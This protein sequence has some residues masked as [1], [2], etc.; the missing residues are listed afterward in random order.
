M[1]KQSKLQITLNN[2]KYTPNEPATKKKIRGSTMMFINNCV[3][4]VILTIACRFGQL[5]LP[6]GIVLLTATFLFELW[7]FR[8][9]SKACVLSNSGDLLTLMKKCYNKKFAI[10]IDVCAVLMLFAVQICYTIIISSYVHQAYD[11]F[12][13]NETCKY[14]D[15]AC[16]VKYRNVEIVIRLII[17]FLILPFEDLITSIDI[18]NYISSFA[19][20]F[21]LVTVIC[22][23][24]RSSVTLISGQ[25]AYDKLFVARQPKI[26][27]KPNVLDIFVDFTGMFAMFSLQ[28]VI[29]PLYAE[30]VGNRDTKHKI[31]SKAS[32][33]AT[34]ALYVLYMITGVLGCL[35]FYGDNQPKYQYDNILVNYSSS[36][37]LMSI[38][39][40]IYVLVIM[41]GYPVVIFQIRAS[42]ASW[43]GFHLSWCDCHCYLLHNR[44][45][46]ALYSHDF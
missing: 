13:K 46:Y 15:T 34:F 39:R 6:L 1:Q 44:V 3:G 28:P 16:L 25:L 32:D 8:V 14:N 18:L 9:I 5:G 45:V 35:V 21:V 11:L 40:I 38:I 41:I 20:I 30:L 27:L 22:I 29:P 36:D 17:G 23:I 7:A 33:I 26:P 2:E 24:I 19:V 4:D 10:L 31:V 37:I 42:M 12:T 43:F